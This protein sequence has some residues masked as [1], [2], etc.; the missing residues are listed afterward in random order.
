MKPEEWLPISIS[1]VALG[2]SVYTAYAQQRDATQARHREYLQSFLLPLQMTLE[3][4]RRLHH[5]LTA[6][7]KLEELEYAPDYVQR[8]LHHDLPI[9]DPRRITWRTDIKLLMAE[10]NKA[11]QLIETHIG[12]VPRREFAAA[13]MDFKMHARNWEAMWDA[14]LDPDNAKALSLAG[15]DRLRTESYPKTLDVLLAAEVERV[16][17]DAGPDG[18]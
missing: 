8:A 5:K 4:N 10:N 15:R 7:S 2:V 9:D 12:R 16:R 17:R 11:V 18:R 3:L 13:L 14:V 1:V 6:D